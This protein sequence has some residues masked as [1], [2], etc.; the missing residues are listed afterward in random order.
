MLLEAR[1]GRT[2]CFWENFTKQKLKIALDLV[3]AGQVRSDQVPDLSQGSGSQ[4]KCKGRVCC[5]GPWADRTKT[6]QVFYP[7]EDMATEM[8]WTSWTPTLW[9]GE[10]PE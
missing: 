9:A 5:H 8:F 2:V 1:A 3:G 7:Y 10:A 6:W 4:S